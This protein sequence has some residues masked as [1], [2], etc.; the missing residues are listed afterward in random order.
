M[1]DR[2]EFE[3]DYYDLQCWSRVLARLFINQWSPASA[4]LSLDPLRH[5]VHTRTPAKPCQGE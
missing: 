5:L 4:S 2:S 1:E 3:V